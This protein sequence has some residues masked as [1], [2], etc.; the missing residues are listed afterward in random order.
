MMSS[1]GAS[2][3]FFLIH[4]EQELMVQVFRILCL[5]QAWIIWIDLV[6]QIGF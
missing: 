1:F 3:F 5:T 6:G 4:V 2:S